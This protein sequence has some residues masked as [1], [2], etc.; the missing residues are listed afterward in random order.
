MGDASLPTLLNL[1]RRP[2]IVRL[3]DVT[4]IAYKDN[5]GDSGLIFLFLR[6]FLSLL[7]FSCALLYYVSATAL[8]TSAMLQITVCFDLTRV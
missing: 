8:N 5:E 3:R 4:S 1:S 6:R 2:T 7:F